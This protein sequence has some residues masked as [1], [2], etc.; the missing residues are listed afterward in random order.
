MSA[1]EGPVTE[2][3]HTLEASEVVIERTVLLDQDDHVIDI[4]QFAQAVGMG[5]LVE[6][7]TPP[8][9]YRASDASSARAAMPLS[10]KSS[11][12]VTLWIVIQALMRFSACAA[13]DALLK[14]HGEGNSLVSAE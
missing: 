5:E 6:V 3:P 9:P 2:A 14:G 13:E 4:A 7:P 1:H 8:Q 12:R 11:R 10:F